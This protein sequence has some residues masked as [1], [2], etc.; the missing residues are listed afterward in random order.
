M[1]INELEDFIYENY[2]R[3]I[4][5]P[6]ENSYYSMKHQKKNLKLFATK[7]TEKYL[8]LVIIK[9]TTNLI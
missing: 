7:L 5:F 9:N 1:T 8:I 2:Y 3:R 6:E 4:G